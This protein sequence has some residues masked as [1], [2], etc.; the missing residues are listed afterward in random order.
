MSMTVNLGV[1]Q[2]SVYRTV[3]N[4]DKDLKLDDSAERIYKAVYEI[5]LK[6][7]LLVNGFYVHDMN[8]K[9]LSAN[10]MLGIRV[11]GHPSNDVLEDLRFNLKK[12]G[13][14]I[15]KPVKDSSRNTFFNIFFDGNEQ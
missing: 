11:F 13:I 14:V 6:R 1:L 2:K 10:D 3:V 12:E 8:T 15:T 5:I 7:N 4:L 9:I